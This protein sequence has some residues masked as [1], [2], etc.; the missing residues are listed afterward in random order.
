M[1]SDFFDIT[2]AFPVSALLFDLYFVP[3][4]SWRVSLWET[5]QKLDKNNEQIGYQGK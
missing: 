5:N 1:K 4:D 3:A 2:V